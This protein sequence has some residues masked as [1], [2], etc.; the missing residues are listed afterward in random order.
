MQKAANQSEGD[1]KG[2]N[3]GLEE[4]GILPP[5]FPSSEANLERKYEVKKKNWKSRLIG[6]LPN[7][8][9]HPPFSAKTIL[10]QT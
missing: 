1:E 4:G 9:N 2:W 8:K 7:P 10:Q 6:N 3:G 5:P